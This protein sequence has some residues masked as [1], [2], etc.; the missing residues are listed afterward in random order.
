ML[1]FFSLS[2]FSSSLLA[3]HKKI[4][5]YPFSNSKSINILQ[6]DKFLC[7]GSLDQCPD[8]ETLIDILDFNFPDVWENILDK[9]TQITIKIFQDFS[10]NQYLIFNDPD[11]KIPSDLNSPLI[12]SVVNEESNYYPLFNFRFD[13]TFPSNFEVIYSG[14]T[15][16]SDITISIPKLTIK[17]SFP[18]NN[19]INHFQLSEL[20]IEASIFSNYYHCYDFLY[21]FDPEQFEYCTIFLFGNIIHYTLDEAYYI[22]E[23]KASASSEI[24][25]FKFPHGLEEITDLFF[26]FLSYE[27]TPTI[28]IDY[29]SN[30]NYSNLTPDNLLI[31]CNAIID[32]THN[33]KIAQCLSYNNMFPVIQFHNSQDSETFVKKGKILTKGKYLLPFELKFNDVLESKLENNNLGFTL[34]IVGSQLSINILTLERPSSFPYNSNFIGIF[35]LYYDDISGYN[36]SIVNFQAISNSIS[37]LYN[38]NIKPNADWNITFS[39]FQSKSESSKEYK[40]S[41][42]LCGKFVVLHYLTFISKSQIINNVTPYRT[43]CFGIGFQYGSTFIGSDLFANYPMSNSLHAKYVPNQNNITIIDSLHISKIYLSGELTYPYVTNYTFWFYTDDQWNEYP[44]GDIIPNYSKIIGNEWEIA[45]LGKF[46]CQ[47]W[48]NPYQSII[49]FFSYLTAD[50]QP[51]PDS[52]LDYTCKNC[53]DDNS[54]TCIKIKFVKQPQWV[55]RNITYGLTKLEIVGISLS[56]VIVIIGIIIGGIYLSKIEKKKDD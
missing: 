44:S 38:I 12:I 14:I 55:Q 54:K 45:R 56:Y 34:T 51:N 53:D 17:D 50:Y 11:G 2:K 40:L 9:T 47:G 7:F 35:N 1:F 36:F 48:K 13:T 4:N 25:K 32:L 42:L 3:P 46:D 33:W 26:D 19:K 5:Y 22:Y 39:F 52:V 20:H 41:P 18:P 10:E 29:N 31:G 43:G 16:F 37:G 6:E 49:N 24:Q 8:N 23:Y 28:V 15:F 27:E 21:N 30:C